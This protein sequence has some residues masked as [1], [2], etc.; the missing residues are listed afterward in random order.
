MVISIRLG[1][2]ASSIQTVRLPGPT[3]VC[4]AETPPRHRPCPSARRWRVHTK[5]SPEAQ[6]P[7]ASAGRQPAPAPAWALHKVHHR[8]PPLASSLQKLLPHRAGSSSPWDCLYCSSS[9]G[10]EQSAKP[11]ERPLD[12][13]PSSVSTHRSGP[14]HYLVIRSAHV[15]KGHPESIWEGSCWKRNPPFSGSYCTGTDQAR[16]YSSRFRL[17]TWPSAK[18][19]L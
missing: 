17:L 14:L 6:A 12:I 7:P 18:R 15:D 13:A 19:T 5:A 8:S 2:R 10:Q 16:I 11:G 3:S 9:G 4:S 1:S